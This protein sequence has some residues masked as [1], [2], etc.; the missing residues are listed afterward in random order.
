MNNMITPSILYNYL[1]CPHKVWRDVHGPAS[2]KIDETNPF[3]ELLWEKGV[4]HEKSV[5]SSL[6]EFKDLSEGTREERIAQTKEAIANK[7]PLIYQP[8]I[9]HENLYGIPD[10]LKLID[11]QYYPVDI[12]SGMGLEHVN[13]KA[14]SDTRPKRDYAVQL[15]M[16]IDILTR[17]GHISHKTGYIL[18]GNSEEV[19]YDLNVAMGK[20]LPD[21]YWEFYL[22]TKRTVEELTSNKTQNLPAIASACK[23]CNWHDSC[24]KW[25]MTQNDLTQLYKS[26]RKVRDV[27]S[28]DLGLSKVD[29]VIDLDVK[30]LLARKKEDSDFLKGVGKTTLDKLKLRANL[31][32]NNLEPVIHKPVEFPEVQYEL[33][34]DIEDDPT[35]EF[36]YMHGVYERTGNKEKFIDF[37]A[38]GISSEDEKT[39]WANFWK[40]IKTLPENDYAIY[41]Y[42]HHE[43]TTYKKLQK[44][45]PKVISEEELAAFFAN[46]H[47]ID[48]YR[49]VDSSTDWPVGS[50]SLKELATYLGFS[51]RDETPSGALSIKWFN[52]YI[53]K[54]DE[55]TLKRIL[56]YNEDDCK[57]TM[58]LK[59][60]L[61]VLMQSYS[62]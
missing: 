53:E 4:Q 14:D 50:Y 37:T 45:Y 35:R 26:G 25:A 43:E 38:K 48:L 5:V 42:S 18:D 54:K 13:S 52:D 21:S 7:E 22:K 41:Y 31:F 46:P 19:E 3:V 24:K 57:A 51:W 28:K 49:F 10:L 20:R 40:Y 6:G 33:F 15:A 29:E 30:D 58:V 8:I 16:H 23:L 61:C 2:E 27:L 32:Q 60:G 62:S 56:E 55:E 59:D 17:L 44:K 39:T 1:Q 34:F 12:K 47:V 11:G 9:T 36:V